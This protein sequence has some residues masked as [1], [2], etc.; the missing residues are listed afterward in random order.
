MLSSRPVALGMDSHVYPSK[1]PGRMKGRVENAVP[2]TVHGKEK[3]IM[4]QTP[5]HGGKQAVHQKAPMTLA[6]GKQN[7]SSRPI[8]RILGDKTPFPNRSKTQKFETPA[9]QLAKFPVLSFLEPQSHLP[10]DKTPGSQ[11]RPSS[12]RKQD[13]VPRLSAG[14]VFE[15]PINNGN[16]WDVS[17]LNIVVPEAD[18]H[19]VSGDDHDEIEYMP[20]NTLHLA[21][22]PTWDFELPN[23]KEVGK[24]LFNFA[25]TCLHDDTPIAEI[26]I[27]EK[28]VQLPGW[29]MLTVQ[30][31]GMFATFAIVRDR[32]LSQVI[33]S[34]D[35]FRHARAA[36]PAKQ[37]AAPTKKPSAVAPKS[38]LLS[39]PLIAP[40]PIPT[41]TR[42]TST[43]KPPKAASKS[44]ASSTVRPAAAAQR[45]QGAD[46][47]KPIRTAKPAANPPQS[48]PARP[49]TSAA[50][51][52]R[53]TTTLPSTVAR[54]SAT[55]TSQYKTLPAPRSGLNRVV[56][57]GGKKKEDVSK[58]VDG[59]PLII[60]LGIDLDY[61]FKFDV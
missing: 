1:T 32:I 16:H 19:E 55:S 17:D 18:V 42:S 38:L 12:A 9:P 5:F 43:L 40:R 30:E 34:D 46:K 26:E 2:M 45:T 56:P 4:T 20:P 28:D 53:P 47:A 7:V 31:L 25:H 22:Q 11:L 51:R 15:T 14:K 23:Y 24:A 8:V 21:F 49:A 37:T 61:D 35:P 39:R 27:D 10:H 6:Q 48:I 13:R 36:P 44:S 33:E 3:E 57:S 54:R 58:S 50:S 29:D 60:D 52:S 59:N 41:S